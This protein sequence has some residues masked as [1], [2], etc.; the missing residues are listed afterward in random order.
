M[1]VMKFAQLPIGTRFRF[2]GQEYTR[3]S[4]LMAQPATAGNSRL[5]P[6]SAEVTALDAPPV[7]PEIPREIPAERVDAAMQ[8]LA[9]EIN[10]L[11]HAS[12]LDAV[13]L[14]QLSRELQQAFER[15]RAVLYPDP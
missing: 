10:D 7:Q 8:G 3:T 15:A 14:S 11:L 13:R 2:Q 12:G 6:R 1:S 5:I 4:N 9:G